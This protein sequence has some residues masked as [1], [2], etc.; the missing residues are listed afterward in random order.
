MGA[1]EALES[2]PLVSHAF[3]SGELGIDKVVELTRFATPE[4]EAGLI[5]WACARASGTIRRRAELERRRERSE[6]VEADHERFVR[7]CYTDDGARFGL[8]AELPVDQG[9]VIATALGRLAEQI[10]SVPGVDSP[11]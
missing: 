7:W 3:G 8:D 5:S 4:T 9:A 1:A 2:L 6:V 10:P 11:A